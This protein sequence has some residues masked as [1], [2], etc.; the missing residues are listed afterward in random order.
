MVNADP[1]PWLGQAKEAGARVMCQVQNFED[2]DA[3]VDA[4]ADVL[5]AQGSEAGGH[6]GAMGLLPF[7][8]G[9]VARYGEVPVLAAGGIADG[10]T[11][12]AVLTA[13]AD[14]AWRARRVTGDSA[15]ADRP[16][17]RRRA[18][19]AAEGARVNG[20]LVYRF[21]DPVSP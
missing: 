10:R 5:V 20:R 12:A 17:R 11:L 6:T 4:G 18:R 1:Q 16:T 14:G 2:A 13:G 15:R 8:A 7:L 19:P 21:G 9:V 3:A